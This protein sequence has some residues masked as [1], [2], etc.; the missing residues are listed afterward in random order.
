MSDDEKPAV[1]DIA[2]I[3]QWLGTELSKSNDVLMCILHETNAHRA[4]FLDYVHNTRGIFLSE[5]SEERYAE[6][7]VD[8]EKWQLNED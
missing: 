6:L 7:E 8:F 3:L 4:N 2:E 1:T 5:I